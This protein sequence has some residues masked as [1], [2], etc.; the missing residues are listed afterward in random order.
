MLQH[1]PGR[2]FFEGF[3]EQGLEIPPIEEEVE[4]IRLLGA[5]VLA[6][7]LN[8]KGLSRSDLEA[9]RAD[10][11]RRVKLPVALPLE[12]GVDALVPVLAG[13]VQAEKAA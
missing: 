5:R 1:A 8:G 2:L 3:E 4:L 13:Y 9:A 10:L 6:L 11:A 12:E 7:T